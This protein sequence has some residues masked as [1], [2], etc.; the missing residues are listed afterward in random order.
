MPN[1]PQH[2]TSTVALPNAEGSIRYD[3][4]L[5]QARVG[6]TFIINAI[7]YPDSYDTS[8]PDAVLQ[9]AAEEMVNGNPSNKLVRE[10]RGV[11]QGL[12]SSDFTLKNQDVGIRSR[13]ILKGKRLY[14]L[15]VAD[16]DPQVLQDSF[17]RFANS[18]KVENK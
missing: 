14:V 3:V 16:R 15:T 8:N 5:A 11:H 12:P 17:S 6:T 13:A 7:Q 4:Y 1:L 9:A 18:F 2:V 10:E